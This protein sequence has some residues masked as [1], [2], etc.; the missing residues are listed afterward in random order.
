MNQFIGIVI[1]FGLLKKI[2]KLFKDK[3]STIQI[4]IVAVVIRNLGLAGFINDHTAL[5]FIFGIL[6]GAIIMSIYT[7]VTGKYY[8][9]SNTKPLEKSKSRKKTDTMLPPENYTLPKADKNLPK[10]SPNIS[11]KQ[12]FDSEIK[13]TAL[14]AVIKYLKIKNYTTIKDNSKEFDLIAI[15]YQGRESKVTIICFEH[16]RKDYLIKFPLDKFEKILELGRKHRLFV[17]TNCQKDDD[18]EYLGNYV[19]IY[20]VEEPLQDMGFTLEN[21]YYLSDLK[22]LKKYSYDQEISVRD[23][24]LNF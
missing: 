8:L 3:K 13:K 11:A 20:S 10:S 22:T 2:K 17:V 14:A 24:D 23:Q 19:N 21:N 9:Q 1:F 6:D 7:L 15:D 18:S 12:S 16:K 5:D 4:L